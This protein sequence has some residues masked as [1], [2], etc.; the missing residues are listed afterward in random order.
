VSAPREQGHNEGLNGAIAAVLR[1]ERASANITIAELATRSGVPK[2]TIQ[3]LLAA[4][5]PITMEALE[6][7]CNG[8][9]ISP[10]EVT[11]SAVHRMGEADPELVAHVMAGFTRARVVRNVT[12]V[13][14]S[15]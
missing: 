11:L 12:P 6:R 9:Q 4:R 15:S 13:S 8:L 2:V 3:R 1:G 5:R 14:E 7:M 10:V